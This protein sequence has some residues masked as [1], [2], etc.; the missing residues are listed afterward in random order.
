MPAKQKQVLVLRIPPED[1]EHFKIKNLSLSSARFDNSS[2]QGDEDI[3]EE[4]I[5][6]STGHFIIRFKFRKVKLDYKKNRRQER[7]KPIIYKQEEDIVDKTFS[8][9]GDCIVAA[10]CHDL[11]KIELDDK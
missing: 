3:I 7:A 4:E 2:Y 5:V 6:T 9:K 11:K 10:L 8:Y 1:L